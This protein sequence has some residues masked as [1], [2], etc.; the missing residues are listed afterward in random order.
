M[1]NSTLDMVILCRD[2]PACSMHPTMRTR[3]KVT[4]L[5]SDNLALESSVSLRQ[6]VENLQG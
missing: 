5:P 1:S 3:H 6:G 4:K 2:L